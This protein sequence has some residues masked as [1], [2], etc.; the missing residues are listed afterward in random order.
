MPRKNDE[1]PLRKFRVG[2]A[3]SCQSTASVVFQERLWGL[4]T[5]R[6]EKTH[7]MLEVQGVIDD[8]EWSKHLRCWIYHVNHRWWV[9]RVLRHRPTPGDSFESLMLQLKVAKWING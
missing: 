3:V 2:D 4:I 5:T 8:Y 1:I 7:P 6:R 9:E